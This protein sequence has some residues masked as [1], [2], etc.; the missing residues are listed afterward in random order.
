[1]RVRQMIATPKFPICAN[2]QFRSEK[3]GFM[4]HSNQP[5]SIA[6][7]LPDRVGARRGKA[8]AR[9][10]EAAEIGARGSGGREK[11]D[12]RRIPIKALAMGGEEQIV[13]SGAPEIDRPAQAGGLD[14]KPR[15]FGENDIAVAHR[16][17]RIGGRIGLGLGQGNLAAVLDL[18]RRRVGRWEIGLRDEAPSQQNDRRQDDR[19]DHVLVIVHLN[20]LLVPALM[21][22]GRRRIPPRGGSEAGVLRPA[23]FR[24][25]PHSGSRR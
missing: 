22:P 5:Q 1:M 8:V 4:N 10:A 6:A 16:L 14:P 13:D 7:R 12:R 21:V 23:S 2:S 19:Q 20:P 11:A 9:P 3:I 15:G 17:G 18:R 24:A 25:A